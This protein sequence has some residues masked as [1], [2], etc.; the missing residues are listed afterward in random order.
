MDNQPKMNVPRD[1]AEK[2]LFE[3]IKEGE[4]LFGKDIKSSSELKQLKREYK[5][6]NSYN[7]ELLLFLFSNEKKKMNIMVLM[8]VW[9]REIQYL[10]ILH[11]KKK[12]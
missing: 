2:L 5:R 10:K 1:E 9:P 6:W 12:E 3:R 11:Y 8:L 7:R 4:V